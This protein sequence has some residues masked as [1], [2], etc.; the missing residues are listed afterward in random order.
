ML[1]SFRVGGVNNPI[2]KG[3]KP[4]LSRPFRL[5]LC[6]N[7][8]GVGREVSISAFFQRFLGDF[9]RASN[10]FLGNQLPSSNLVITIAMSDR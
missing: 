1:A 2:T 4:Y 10:L 8:G 3:R 9:G 7:P 5:I 6:T